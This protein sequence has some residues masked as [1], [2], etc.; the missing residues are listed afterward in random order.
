MAVRNLARDHFQ[1]VSASR[2]APQEVTDTAHDTAHESVLRALA[3]HKSRLRGIA[4]IEGKIEYKRTAIG[5]LMPWVQGVIDGDRGGQD[6]VVAHALPWLLDIGEYDMGLTVGAYVLRHRLIMPDEYK[7]PPAAVIAEV[8][9]DDALKALDTGAKA[10]IDTLRSALALT[11][12]HDM[13]DQV[14]AKLHKALGLALLPEKIEGTHT[15]E[16]AAPILESCE[17]LQRA[18]ALFPNVGVKKPMERAKRYAEEHEKREAAA[19]ASA[20]TN[21]HDGASG[22]GDTQPDREIVG[23]PPAGPSGGDEGSTP[24]DASGAVPKIPAPATS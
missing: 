13:H 6:P 17:H 11:D 21:D 9:A 10:D 22:T 15:A 12:G 19:Q 8:I 1:R 16:E 7:R 20:A 2:A 4:S 24:P 23:A 18:F 3:A 14:R 5:D